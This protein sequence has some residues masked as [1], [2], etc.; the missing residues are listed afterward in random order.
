MIP[1]LGSGLYFRWALPVFK[2][3]ERGTHEELLAK[4]GRYYQLYTGSFE[5]E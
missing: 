2:R 4:K 5:L 3:I 1:F